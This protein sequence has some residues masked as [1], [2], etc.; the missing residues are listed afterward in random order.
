[1]PQRGRIKW[2]FYRKGSLLS[3]ARGGNGAPTRSHYAFVVIPGRSREHWAC[4]VWPLT[5][6]S[7]MWGGVEGGMLTW[8]ELTRVA[9]Q[10]DGKSP[11]TIAKGG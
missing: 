4:L 7:W 2:E 6:C 11:L 1:M 5:P 10:G 8:G 9:S 3:L